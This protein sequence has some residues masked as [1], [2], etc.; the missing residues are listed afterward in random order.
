MSGN[1][2][3]KVA[4]MTERDPVAPDTPPAETLVL[5]LRQ[6]LRDALAARDMVA[7]SALRS[8]LAAIGNAEAV[9]PATA[10]GGHARP[11]AGTTSE[12]FAAAVAGLGAGEITR[13]TLGAAEIGQLVRTEVDDRLAAA[14]DYER[15]GR[16][17]RAA[18]LRAEADVLARVLDPARP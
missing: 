16:T 2:A 18:R 15:G 13:R 4:D 1:V 5:R 12:H 8:A 3:A 17:D 7:V 14:A 6:S 11:T 10:Q 9:D